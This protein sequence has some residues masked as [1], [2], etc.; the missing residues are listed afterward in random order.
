MLGAPFDGILAGVTT[1]S[2]GANVM[3]EL[4]TRE[5]RAAPA[6][7]P[8]A[9][10]SYPA[11]VERL[12]RASVEKAHD[13]Y[14]DVDW[15]APANRI[16]AGDARL[17]IDA[18]HPLARTDWYDGLSPAA[19]VR[20]GTEL[21]AQQLKY[22]IGFEA[23]LSR[24]LLKYAQRVPNGS[25]EYRY[26]MHEVVEEGRHSMMFQELINRLGT[27]ARPIGRLLELLDDR[28]AN[29]GGWFETL[30]FFA[31]L[32]GEIFID[33]ENRELLRRPV[34]TV[35]PLIR[36]VIQIHVTE[37]ARHICFAERFLAERLPR[38]TWLERGVLAWT[39]PVIFAT[40]KQML[41]EPDA[42][43]VARYRI[44]RS[45]LR[46]AYGKGSAHQRTTSR[47]MEPVKRL[48]EEHRLFERRHAALWRALGLSE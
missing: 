26:V 32:A 1:E 2:E 36:R 8:R 6:R 30:F 18:S 23:V 43:L 19:R 16:V 27:D 29:L 39:V 34:A 15:D 42:R 21:G 4:T 14:R 33:H 45:T 28:V 22:G 17:C 11:I 9:T 38:A 3:I 10:E 5:G 25:P 40:S 35:H 48:C 37:E 13:P 7:R 20:F 31:V 41:L 47:L 12:S 24:G 46:E 44:P